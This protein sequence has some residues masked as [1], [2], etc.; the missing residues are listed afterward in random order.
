VK[1]LMT[2]PGIDMVVA[3]GLAAAIGDIG[4]F[5]SPERLVAYLGLNPSVRQS[6]EGPAHHGRITKQAGDRPAHAGRGR[7]VGSALARPAA[8]FLPAGFRPPGPARRRG[9]HR[10]EDRGRGLAHAETR[11]GL[12]LGQTRPGAA[13]AAAPHATT[14]APPGKRNGSAR[15]KAKPRTGASPKVGRRRDQGGRAWA[16]Q[17][18]SDHRLRGGACTS[19]PALRHAVTHAPEKIASDAEKGCSTHP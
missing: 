13:S 15:P 19:V 6:G 11:R 17:R 5:A 9:R 3:V 2:V 14:S 12:H 1:R 16:P 18:R 10:Q 7:L 4:R 8:G